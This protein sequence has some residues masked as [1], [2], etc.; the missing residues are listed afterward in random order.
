VCSFPYSRLHGDIEG[1]HSTHH[2]HVPFK[3]ASGEAMKIRMKIARVSILA[4]RWVYDPFVIDKGCNWP[5]PGY[6]VR[7]VG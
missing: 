2:I 1:H 5:G 6:S 3:T 4:F 7:L